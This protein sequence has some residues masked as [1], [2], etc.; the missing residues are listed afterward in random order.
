MC[1]RNCRGQFHRPVRTPGDSSILFSPFPQEKTKCMQVSSLAPEKQSIL[2]DGLLFCIV[3]RLECAPKLPC[4][5]RVFVN[6]PY[7][8]LTGVLHRRGDPCA[9]PAVR[10][11][12][13]VFAPARPQNVGDCR[14]A[15]A[16]AAPTV[17][18]A[19]SRRGASPLA[20][21]SPFGGGEPRADRLRESVKKPSPRRRGRH[22][23]RRFRLT[24]RRRAPGW[25]GSRRRR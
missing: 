6:S 7:G 24:P 20:L 18:D 16:R 11:V 25:R 14:R 8:A 4:P 10:R 13:Y 15:A 19:G 22:G 12:F 1:N 17:I 9:R 21:P 23:A 5:S 3:R 2:S